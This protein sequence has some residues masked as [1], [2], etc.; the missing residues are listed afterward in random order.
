MTTFAAKS[1]P[2]FGCN[3]QDDVRGRAGALRLAVTL[4][5][6]VERGSADW[7]QV[8]QGFSIT[9]IA[10]RGNLYRFVETVLVTALV[11]SSTCVERFRLI[12]N[13]E[14]LCT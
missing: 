12:R 10:E 6:L 13:N 1:F 4:A 7:T 8:E 14:I 5:Q 3:E 2:R 9:C 11:H